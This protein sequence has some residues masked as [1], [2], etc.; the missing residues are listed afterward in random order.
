[1]RGKGIVL[2]EPSIVAIRQ[3]NGANGKQTVH[4]VGA[5][6]KG[7]LGRTPGS[8][9]AIRP[10]KDGVISDFTVTELMLKHF[11]RKVF[12]ARLFAPSPRIIIS[13]PS[14]STQVERRAIR[15]SAIGAGAS[16]AFLIE[17][18]YGGRA[19]RRSPGQ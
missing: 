17:E 15:E 2:N 1:M 4:A 11:I 3:Q 18:P 6:A 13:V 14:G 19:G 12:H 10:L 9:R 7:M 5:A 8:I 16:K